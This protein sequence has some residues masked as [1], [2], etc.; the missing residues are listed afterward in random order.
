MRLDS[1]KKLDWSCFNQTSYK[2]SLLWQCLYLKLLWFSLVHYRRTCDPLDTRIPHPGKLSHSP[3]STLKQHK[4]KLTIYYE[5]ESKLSYT[6]IIS[7]LRSVCR[8]LKV[9]HTKK[10]TFLVIIPRKGKFRPR[11]ISDGIRLHCFRCS[12]AHAQP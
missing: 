8:R 10:I 2:Q 5:W 3:L 6:S 1:L 12:F 11:V 7:L 4:V 9:C